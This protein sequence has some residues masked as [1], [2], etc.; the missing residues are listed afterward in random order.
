MEEYATTCTYPGAI[1][2]D[3][4]QIRLSELSNADL[5]LVKKKVEV[6]IERRKQSEKEKSEKRKKEKIEDIESRICEFAETASIDQLLEL[7]KK[8][9]TFFDETESVKM[10]KEKE[11]KI[12]QLAFLAYVCGTDRDGMTTKELHEAWRNLHELDKMSFIIEARHANDKWEKFQP[13]QSVEKSNKEQTEEK[14][15]I[16]YNSIVTHSVDFA[17]GYNEYFRA[18]YSRL[19][20]AFGEPNC[21]TFNRKAWTIA[22]SD[23]DTE[24]LGIV[25]T[26]D[27]DERHPFYFC[28]FIVVGSKLNI[29][30]FLAWFDE[31]YPQPYFTNQKNQGG[32]TEDG[33]K[34]QNEKRNG[35]KN[36]GKKR[37]DGE[38]KTVESIHPIKNSISHSSVR[39]VGDPKIKTDKKKEPL[40]K[41]IG[42]IDDFQ[43]QGE[44][45]GAWFT[46]SYNKI[47]EIFGH[48]DD[49]NP[50]FAYW[51]ITNV[52]SKE[53]FKLGVNARFVH[54]EEMKTRTH[55]HFHI[56]GSSKDG[57]LRFAQWFAVQ[58]SDN[59]NLSTTS[60]TDLETTHTFERSPRKSI[61]FERY[62]EHKFKASYSKVCKLFGGPFISSL[63]YDPEWVID[64]SDGKITDVIHVS[65][66][67]IPKAGERN[68]RHFIVCG[69]N[70]RILKLF[71]LYVV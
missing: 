39:K 43:Q 6:I 50:E 2:V 16:T 19:V 70:S 41:R 53:V 11:A 20:Q 32:K 3:R 4:L 26:N 47:V 30:R 48:P 44:E 8:V 64:Y 17:L 59:S 62:V 7:K 24:M 35:E 28:E 58:T 1:S 25:C 57:R 18:S 12:E 9:E 67:R 34:N 66:D 21:K 33:Q 45:D 68:E 40:F 14:K 69:E 49:R 13:T 27:L 63:D 38:K 31:T 42:F 10:E 51:F 29:V 56:S 46:S 60:N 22:R 55:K 15:P 71:E 54:S 65:C 61:G 5:L 52:K 23:S 37:E 36:Q